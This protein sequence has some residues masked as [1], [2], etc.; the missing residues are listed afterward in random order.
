MWDFKVAD[1]KLAPFLWHTS[2]LL[3]LHETDTFYSTWLVWQ[4]NS[5]EFLG[6]YINFQLPFKRTSGSID[7]RDLELDIDIN[8]DLSFTWKNMDEYEKAID[9]GLIL[10]EWI[11][12]IEEV[13]PAIFD[14]LENHRYPFDGSWLNWRPDPTWTPPTLP[15]NWDKI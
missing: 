11:K 2:R 12:G 7:T 14:R 5:N 4:E 3:I 9:C 15:A 10:P 6:Y 1:W 13:K 8:P